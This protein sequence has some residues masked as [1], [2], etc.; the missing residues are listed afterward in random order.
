M[1]KSPGAIRG[2]FF[3]GCLFAPWRVQFMQSR[4]ANGSSPPCE[5]SPELP[6]GLSSVPLLFLQ[7]A[8]FFSEAVGTAEIVFNI[9]DAMR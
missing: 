3:D 6:P 5:K 1:Q 7:A 9:C 4:T 2:F 8:A